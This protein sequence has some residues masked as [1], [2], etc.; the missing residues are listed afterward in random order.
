VIVV[1]TLLALA[2]PLVVYVALQWLEPREV[3]LASLALIALRLLFT[4]PAR[5]AAHARSF[6]APGAAVV[7][8]SSVTLFANDARTLMLTPALV[9]LALLVT[10]RASFLQRETTVRHRPRG[11]E[12]L[13]PEARRTAAG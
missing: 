7:L 13:P 3:A 9:S 5:L 4:S 12:K 10:F 6:A 11:R 1:Q 2:Y 8:A